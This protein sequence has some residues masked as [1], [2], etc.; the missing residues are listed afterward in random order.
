LGWGE[1][2]GVGWGKRGRR[3]IRAWN[4]ATT[5]RTYKKIR[6]QVLRAVCLQDAASLA[7]RASMQFWRE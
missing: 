3:K 5:F 6:E 4:L 7:L 1:V 2:E